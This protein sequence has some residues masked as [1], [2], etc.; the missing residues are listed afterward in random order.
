MYVGWLKDPFTMPQPVFRQPVAAPGHDAVH[1]DQYLA[2][3]H[4]PP[5]NP[6]VTPPGIEL[7]TI[8]VR[9][10]SRGQ[11]SPRRTRRRL[12][13]HRGSYGYTR[14]DARSCKPARRLHACGTRTSHPLTG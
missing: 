7:F 9:P 12:A 13:D 3:L 11:A 10:A 5:L 6:Q 14:P 2:S 4:E 8:D 1:P